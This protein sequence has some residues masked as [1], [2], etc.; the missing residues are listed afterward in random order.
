MKQ[1]IIRVNG[2][3]YDVEVEEVKSAGTSKPTATVSPAPAGKTVSNPSR[4]DESKPSSSPSRPE[5]T[6][7]SDRQVTSPM[8]GTIVKILVDT[9]DAV[10]QG[11]VLLV[12]EAMKMENDVM[13]DDD[14][15]IRTVDV[16]V[17]QIVNAGDLLM[18]FE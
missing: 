10:S 3:A 16:G 8:A 6:P 15:I 13:A 1:Y 9:G 14:G 17:G 2:K 12:L 11:D 18:T 5:T 7:V 4:A